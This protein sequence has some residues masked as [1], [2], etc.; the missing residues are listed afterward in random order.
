[1]LAEITS[2]H[3]LD[4]LERMVQFA[5]RRHELITNNIANISTPYFRPTD[6]DADSFRASLGDAIEK[7]RDRHGG[8]RGPLDPQDTRDVEFRRHGLA[9]D[10][11]PSGANIMFHD[12]NDRDV[13]RLMQNLAE[14]TLVFR[15]ATELLRSRYA[16]LTSAIR[17][18]L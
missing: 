18:R 11:R 8:A 7:R 6:L 17:E 12:R 4:V 15:Q 14:N 10:P 16:L 9:V 3:G 1:M 5:G 13:E 2:S